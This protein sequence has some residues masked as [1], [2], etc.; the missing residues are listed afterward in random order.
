MFAVHCPQHGR[1]VLLSERHIESF[2]NTAN[3]IEIRWVCWCGR[4]GVT[5]TGRLHTHPLV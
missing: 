3:G 1:E 2:R 4:H 5:R